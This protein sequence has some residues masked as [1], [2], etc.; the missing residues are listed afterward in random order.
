MEKIMEKVVVTVQKPIYE[1]VQIGTKDIQTNKFIAFDGTEFDL[2]FMCESYEKRKKAENAEILALSM[3]A[4]KK[5]NW[6]LFNTAED[7]AVYYKWKHPYDRGVT[8]AEWLTEIHNIK[9]YPQWIREDHQCNE[10]TNYCDEYYY[11]SF[12]EYSDSY[13]RTREKL[14][15]IS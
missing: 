11:E 2:Q 5:D 6:L 8:D 12:D 3:I 4:D 14:Y 7:F 10:D 13:T 9:S 1:Q 15:G